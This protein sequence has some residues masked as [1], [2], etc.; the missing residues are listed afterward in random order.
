MPL[1]VACE[2]AERE[3]DDGNNI[4][5]GQLLGNWSLKDCVLNPE[6]ETKIS[7]RHDR[8]YVGTHIYYM[9]REGIQYISEE[10]RTEGTF[11]F[12]KGKVAL[13]AEK[14]LYRE[15]NYDK[16]TGIYELDEWEDLGN[17]SSDEREPEISKV[18]L[19][20]D[21]KVLVMNRDDNCT[22][23]YKEGTIMPSDTSAL[24][25]TW[26]SDYKNENYEHLYALKITDDTLELIFGHFGDRFVCKYDYKEG[27][28]SVSESKY[29]YFDDESGVEYNMDDPF[30]NEWVLSD[31]EFDEE[32][33]W[34]N[35]FPM[36]VEGSTAYAR[37]DWENLEF[38]KQ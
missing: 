8:T 6:T 36:I 17:G 20:L 24:K 34:F 5:A 28:V 29:Y 35:G 2:R 21:G 27:Y 7:F 10:F 18:N 23:L 16:E 12:E 9:Y 19:I 33:I 32:D 1:F 11:Q 30:A 25:G 13:W 14:T 26:I 31:E 37:I 22:F 15:G 3:I 4:I 38:K